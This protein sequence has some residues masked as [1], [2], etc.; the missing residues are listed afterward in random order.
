MKIN[1]LSIGNYVK[2]KNTVFE[3]NAITTP[4]FDKDYY[5]IE[6]LNDN[7][8]INV[9]LDKIEG[10]ELNKKWIE[11]FDKP[12]IDFGFYISLS[13]A[14]SYYRLFHN[15]LFTG[16]FIDYVHQLQNLYFLIRNEKLI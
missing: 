2:Y 5:I 6:L 3:V 13:P 11:K 9:K 4:D 8:L 16:I 12:L 1:E 15:N 14:N 7:L 10:I